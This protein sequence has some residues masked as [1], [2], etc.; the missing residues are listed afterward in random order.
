MGGLGYMF[1]AP[2][3]AIIMPVID[4]MFY[5]GSVKLLK[6]KNPPFKRAIIFL[7]VINMLTANFTL[8]SL[9]LTSPFMSLKDRNRQAYFRSYI[10]S[11]IKNFENPSLN[12][13]GTLEPVRYT[14]RFSNTGTQPQE[15]YIESS[16]GYENT[17]TVNE[18]RFL[19]HS[20][21][22][23]TLVPGDTD[24]TMEG[25]ID[26]YAARCWYADASPLNPLVVKVKNTGG[27]MGP[28]TFRI[29]DA[30]FYTALHEIQQ[31]GPN[32]GRACL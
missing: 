14:L 23:K 7:L 1:G 5:L 18:Q 31:K 24:M 11:S 15:V 30:S 3:F 12:A 25:A 13:N 4:M 26:L 17:N 27:A 32:D 20:T 9:V 21:Q 19:T 2:F 28:M 6:V 29:E 10:Q 22:L 8:V 16:I